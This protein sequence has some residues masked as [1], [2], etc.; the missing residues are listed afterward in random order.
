MKTKITARLMSLSLALFLAAGTVPTPAAKTAAA[1]QTPSE[2]MEDDVIAYAIFG[3]NV[4]T[5]GMNVWMG[6]TNNPAVQS[7]GGKSAWVLD[8]AEG[9]NARYIYADIDDN[10]L[11]NKSDGTNLIVEV[12][13]FDVSYKQ[14]LSFEYSQY[15]SRN[16]STETIN[17]DTSNH[18]A[19]TVT[20]MDIFDFGGANAW[21]TNEWY[22]QNVLA[23]NSLSDGDFRLGVY[24]STMGFS[25]YQ[26]TLIHSIKVRDPKRKST[27]NIT[28]DTAEY[29][30]AFSEGEDID[31][32]VTF[33]NTRAP[34][35]S[36]LAGETEMDV[37]Y[38]VIGKHDG[39]TYS[40]QK[41]KM[42][43]SDGQK[44]KK[45]VRIDT[46]EL[47]GL[48]YI[49]IEAENAEKG[50]YS[51]GQEHFGYAI[52]SHGVQNP[53]AGVQI[54][55]VP[56]GYKRAAELM[57]N[58]GIM[59]FR[60]PIT[61]IDATTAAG[62]G[63]SST[64]LGELSISG[65]LLDFCRELQ[66]QGLTILGH[67]G[68]LG[69]RVRQSYRFEKNLRATAYDIPYTEEGIDNWYQTQ[70]ELLRNQALTG[71]GKGDYC[72][73][74]G[75][76]WNLAQ[77][78]N[79][80]QNAKDTA[81]IYAYCYPKLKELYPDL[82]IGGPV[83]SGGATDGW[84]TTFLENGGAGN[85]DFYSYHPYAYEAEPITAGIAYK[86]GGADNHSTIS[87]RRIL[88][89]H[90]LTD[91]PI[92]CTESGTPAF[93][94]SCHG[95][96]QQGAWNAQFYLQLM[97]WDIVERHYH[98]QWYDTSVADRSN[99][100]RNFGM[101]DYKTRP[102]SQYLTLANLNILLN[103]TNFV[104]RLDIKN[105][106]VYDYKTSLDQIPYDNSTKIGDTVLQ[107][108]TKPSTGED[109][110]AMQTNRTSS[111][112]TLNLGTKSV[113]LRDMFGN[114]K[115]IVSDNGVFSFTVTEEPIYVIGKFTKYEYETEPTV[116]VSQSALSAGYSG[117]LDINIVNNTG[118]DIN[119]KATPMA[120]SD[121]AVKTEYSEETGKVVMAVASSAPKGNEPVE[122]EITNKN[123]E[124]LF[125]G[126][127]IISHTDSVTMSGETKV[128]EN[129]NWYIELT[130]T[131]ESD[132]RL[133]GTL[134]LY[135]PTDW[136]YDF[137]TY[138]LEGR[139]TKVV[140][141]PLPDGASE[142][143]GGPASIA[144]VVG[145]NGEGTYY[146]IPVDFA[147]ALKVSEPIKID[148]NL[149][150][151][152]EGWMVMNRPEQFN[153]IV[154]YNNFYRGVTDLNAKVAVRWDDDNF[155]F[156]A[157]V[158]DDN[159]MNNV[160][161]ASM[162]SQ[163]NIQLGVSYNQT[164]KSQFEELS[165][166]LNNG[167][168]KIYRHLSQTSPISPTLDDYDLAIV[169]DGNTLYYELRVS[170]KDL[171]PQNRDPELN[172]IVEGSQMRFGCIVNDSDDGNRKG[173]LFI[174]NDGIGG[175]K[176]AT[177]HAKMYMLGEK[178]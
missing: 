75:N 50:I 94:R 53:K 8:T 13:Y 167:T 79:E 144:Y 159:F 174:A 6:D 177:R 71:N 172:K 149:E 166:S 37:T 126:N 135:E 84:L 26:Q 155:Y 124:I 113:K 25:E 29:A 131:N 5:S 67:N 48:Y 92:W 85:I 143:G 148:G 88:D 1:K 133:E 165:F 7:K 158:Y 150:E 62:Y 42:T 69:T 122:I 14:S 130:V 66:A 152:T 112:V 154:G 40:V 157:E 153:A 47:F 31:I 161:I 171:M 56:S 80:D 52:S 57:K 89:E 129:M 17:Y 163:D 16:A 60:V 74:I 36:K 137:G 96:R 15:I 97:E 125:S 111:D 168:P 45:T 132:A 23:N 164:G 175:T 93:I 58:A 77:P 76:E 38:S 106:E 33:D 87:F 22:L 19:T 21:R 178:K 72:F 2:A 145:E 104:S 59:H 170:W 136:A 107:R 142:K 99:G 101:F 119:V 156:A 147:Y 121:T 146:S 51:W 30:L 49:K 64:H 32:N 141:I 95:E 105:G 134:S 139:E 20:E 28:I 18:A 46:P 103:G 140:Q 11:Y 102:K 39:K 127:V 120:N 63:E 73:E 65:G 91:V 55:H 4:E 176:D 162:W 98:F 24:S 61:G 108:F 81:A 138:P 83:L 100:E 3:D 160:D 151:W 54:G 90:G 78:R 109:I 173:F 43:I 115:E 35:T 82:T 118:N 123:G 86:D 27:M 117:E 114:E 110:V 44:L 169:K 68:F 12:E 41:E 116:G 70:V 128:D 9:N 34:Y 10:I